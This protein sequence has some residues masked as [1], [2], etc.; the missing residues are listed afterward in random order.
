[1]TFLSSYCVLMKVCDNIPFLG[2]KFLHVTK[3][4]HYGHKFLHVTQH[5]DME[6]KQQIHLGFVFFFFL[7]H[8]QHI[9]GHKLHWNYSLYNFKL[10]L[11][12]MQ[13]PGLNAC[14]PVY[15]LRVH[16]HM[17]YGIMFM[18]MTLNDMSSKIPC[19]LPTW[20]CT[21]CIQLNSSTA[22]ELL[23]WTEQTSFLQCNF[24]VKKSTSFKHQHTVMFSWHCSSTPQSQFITQRYRQLQLQ[25][26][27]FT[28][29][30][31]QSR[32]R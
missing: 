8:N 18:H 29:Q 3:T 17:P 32:W 19:T 6:N 7:H 20:N 11:M 5:Y 24:Y 22:W 13:C 16:E 27:K 26:F 31:H 30:S 12:S 10:A 14:V 1:M 21:D 9:L 25:S 28:Y 4:Q 2:H 23:S 15:L